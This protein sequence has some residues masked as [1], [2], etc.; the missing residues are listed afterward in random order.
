MNLT[1]KQLS[2]EHIGKTVTLEVQRF[3]N[4][5]HSPRRKLTGIITAIQHDSEL[6]EDRALCDPESRVTATPSTVR[7][8]IDD[9]ETFRFT[10]EREITIEEAK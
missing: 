6:T 4:I 1:A 5:D 7:I 3:R 2:G 10:R 8:T 9:R